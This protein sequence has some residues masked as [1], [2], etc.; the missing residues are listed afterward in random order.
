[1]TLV[2]PIKEKILGKNYI[3][4][5]IDKN[6]QSYLDDFFRQNSIEIYELENRIYKK[7]L[8]HSS[9]YQYIYRNAQWIRE[10]IND[11][12]SRLLISLKG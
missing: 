6:L 12:K 8:F 2:C 11:Y 5:A 10:N 3:I 1:M 7:N 9:D 4:L